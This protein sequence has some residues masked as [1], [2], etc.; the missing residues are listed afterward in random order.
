MTLEICSPEFTALNVQKAMSPIDVSCNDGN[1]WS[2]PTCRME[3]CNRSEFVDFNNEIDAED[4]RLMRASFLTAGDVSRMLSPWSDEKN[5]FIEARSGRPSSHG[6]TARAFQLAERV[7][8][9]VSDP[10]YLEFVYSWQADDDGVIPDA[11]YR[12]HQIEVTSTQIAKNGFRAC[13]QL[14]A[15]VFLSLYG[16]I[17]LSVTDAESN[18]A[19]M[20]LW[21]LLGGV[22]VVASA[23]VL[24]IDGCRLF[25]I[26]LEYVIVL[27]FPLQ[28]QHVVWKV[29]IMD[30]F[31]NTWL[32]AVPIVLGIHYAVIRL[33]S[34][35]LARQINK[36]RNDV[37]VKT[38][39]KPPNI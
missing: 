30:L 28:T 27:R 39:P 6:C 14:M 10:D 22:A 2:N 3:L 36:T 11:A 7:A 19:E 21:W 12:I 13:Y 35:L 1:D 8:S 20:N 26:A 16:I 23:L 15:V 17:S 5:Q 24:T 25:M 37:V 31:K 33:L 4:K 34:V 29:S 32:Q 9:T 38:D 18:Q